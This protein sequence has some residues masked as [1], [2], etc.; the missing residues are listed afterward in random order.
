MRVTTY[1]DGRPVS[2]DG[3]LGEA[4]V[5]TTAWIRLTVYGAACCCDFSD[6]F[7]SAWQTLIPNVTGDHDFG[8]AQHGL[9]VAFLVYRPNVAHARPNAFDPFMI[10]MHTS[11]RAFDFS[12]E[13]QWTWDLEEC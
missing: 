13:V 9:E 3:S 11:E 10:K 7:P 12:E 4:V 6:W 8:V 5:V 2:Q 1:W